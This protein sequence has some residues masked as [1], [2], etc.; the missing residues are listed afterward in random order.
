MNFS[1]LQYL[2]IKTFT[3][4]SFNNFSIFPN[5]KFLE[6]SNKRFLGCAP[7]T[8][9]NF[10]SL[11]S[12]SQDCQHGWQK[13]DKLFPQIK[14]LSIQ[15]RDVKGWIQEVGTMESLSNLKVIEVG[16][17]AGEEDMTSF[18]NA[19]SR[20]PTSLSVIR[21]FNNFYDE[22]D[23]ELLKEFILEGQF[24]SIENL[25][26]I[27]IRINGWNDDFSGSALGELSLFK[28][29]LESVGIQLIKHDGEELF[30]DWTKQFEEDG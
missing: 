24:K 8:P 19:I 18:I 21:F 28:A 3:I 22:N 14:N 9:K 10:P 27:Y 5:L 1:G 23:W 30:E 4:K 20:L 25:K 6:L 29:Q 13:F 2:S 26:S 12:L 11:L 17:I 15:Y 7:F 16:W